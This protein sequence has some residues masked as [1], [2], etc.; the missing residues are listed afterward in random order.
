MIESMKETMEYFKCKINVGSS[1]LL[2]SNIYNR[3]AICN[4]KRLIAS[5]FAIE[6]YLKYSNAILT[7]LFNCHFASFYYSAV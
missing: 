1:P 3:Y 4:I 7:N 6:T 2:G 5:V